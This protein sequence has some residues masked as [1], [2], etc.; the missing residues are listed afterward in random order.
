MDM[1]TIF[2]NDLYGVCKSL[3]KTSVFVFPFLI[4]CVVHS[5]VDKVNVIEHDNYWIRTDGNF[6]SCFC[7]KDLKMCSKL[8]SLT[9][10]HILGVNLV[11]PESTL[12]VSML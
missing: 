8:A 10:F 9:K 4:M 1:A 7:S 2:Y 11:L 5:F 6:W 3:S 12:M